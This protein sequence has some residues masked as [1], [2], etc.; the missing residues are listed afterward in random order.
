M[1]RIGKHSQQRR[2]A[3]LK[4]RKRINLILLQGGK[5]D[6]VW[7][8]E[9]PEGGASLNEKGIRRKARLHSIKRDSRKKTKS[10]NERDVCRLNSREKSQEGVSS[11]SPERHRAGWARGKSWQIRPGKGMGRQS[12]RLEEGRQGQREEIFPKGRG[13]D[14][15][16]LIFKVQEKE[17]SEKTGGWPEEGEEPRSSFRQVKKRKKGRALRNAEE[18]RSRLHFMERRTEGNLMFRKKKKGEANKALQKGKPSI[19]SRKSAEGNSFFKRKSV[20]K[21][22]KT[23]QKEGGIRI[24]KQQGRSARDEPHFLPKEES[25]PK[26]VGRELKRR[27][28]PDS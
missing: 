24:N 5:E 21:E 7:D 9:N 4:E 27:C 16:G 28:T 11:V 8:W 14:L 22:E 15:K 1:K 3:M 25:T 19:M 2:D 18:R 17:D 20:R 10:T 26:K 13:H 12:K 23:T 6:I